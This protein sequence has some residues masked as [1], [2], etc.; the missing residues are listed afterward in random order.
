MCDLLHWREQVLHHRAA[1]K[2]DFRR[3]DHAG[4]DPELFAVAFEVGRIQ[5]PAR[6]SPRAE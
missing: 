5:P 4:R 6:G 1:A 2:I 3:D